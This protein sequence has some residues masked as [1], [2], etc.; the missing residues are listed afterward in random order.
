MSDPRVVPG[1]RPLPRRASMDELAQHLLAMVW[2]R[3]DAVNE[4]NELARDERDEHE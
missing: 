2:E 1:P 3:V 4:Y